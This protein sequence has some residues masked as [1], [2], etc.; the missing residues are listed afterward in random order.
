MRIDYNVFAANR[1]GENESC[2]RLND[3][4]K[5]WLVCDTCPWEEEQDTVCQVIDEG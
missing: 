4:C 5:P 3:I 1:N 2:D